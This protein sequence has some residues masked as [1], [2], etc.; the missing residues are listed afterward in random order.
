[1]D[2]V[3][4][5]NTYLEAESSQAE[6]EILEMV[7]FRKRLKQVDERLDIALAKGPPWPEPWPRWYIIRKDPHGRVWYWVVQDEEGDYCVP[8][9]GHVQA[10]MRMDGERNPEVWEK[11]RNRHEERRKAAEK[12][13]AAKSEEFRDKLTERLHHDLDVKIATDG[14]AAEAAERVKTPIDVSQVVKNPLDGAVDPFAP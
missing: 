3:W 4:L 10:L 12:A 5:P 1:M 6:E 9:E 13:R 8:H 11:A 7:D 2:D 14:G